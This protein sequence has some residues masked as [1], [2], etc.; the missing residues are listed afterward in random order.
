MAR[1]D[2]PTGPSSGTSDQLWVPAALLQ[3]VAGSPSLDTLRTG[4]NGWPMWLLDAA[5]AEGLQVAMLL[6]ANW[7]ALNVSIYWSNAGAGS[8][9]VVLNTAWSTQGDGENTTSMVAG[10]TK[11][12][13]APAQY[14]LKV[15]TMDAGLTAAAGELTS[16][17]VA[18]NAAD[19]ADT[20][21][22]DVAIYGV[23]LGK[24]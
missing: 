1:I 18:R 19:A 4:G 20:L 15:T 13:T 12:A 5:S 8:G 23:L 7:S 22:N 3:K 9:D 14:V 17:R 6:P 16:V 10:T 11:T 21:A 24:A 2:V